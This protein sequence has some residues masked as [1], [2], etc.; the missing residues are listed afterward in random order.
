MRK[1]RF[2][3]FVLALLCLVF[4]NCAPYRAAVEDATP[5]AS[6]ADLNPNP[7]PSP[8]PGPPMTPAPAPAPAPLPV[9]LPAPV[10]LRFKKISAAGDKT[11]GVTM[12]DTVQCWGSTGTVVR[13]L[14][15]FTSV[16]EIV[17]G[18][19]FE[20]ILTLGGGVKCMGASNF[21]GQL[22]NGTT[23][24]SPTIPVDVV[25]LSAG[26]TSLAVGSSH[27]CAVTAAGAVVCWGYNANGQLGNNS[28]VASSVP[29]NAVGVN[30]A[31]AVATGS[32]HSCALLNT[33]A[34]RCWGFYYTSGQANDVITPFTI[35][36]L[37]GAK[38]ITAAANTTCVIDAGDG[39]RCW[40]YNTSGILADSS[41]V[42]LQI[43][44]LTGVT[45]FRMSSSGGC[46]LTN[47][48]AVKCLGTP[49][50]G[51]QILPNLSLAIPTDVLP[52]NSAKGLTVS[53]Q[54][55]CL[56]TLTDTVKCMGLNANGQLGN[57]GVANSNT[58]PMSSSLANFR[59][60]KNGFAHSC[61]LTST[62][63]LRC[64]GS[65]SSR[66]LGDNTAIEAAS[67]VD[68]LNSTG[69]VDFAVAR[70]HNCAIIGPTRI[71]RCW[72]NNYVSDVDRG[73]LGNESTTSNGTPVDVAGLSGVKSLSLGDTHSCAVLANDSVVCWGSNRY[74]QL[75]NN[76]DITQPPF[77]NYPP[78]GSPSFTPMPTVNVADVQELASGSAHSCALL[79]S[80]TVKCWGLNTSGQLGVNSVVSSS[81]PADVP[82]LTGIKKI[83]ASGAYTCAITATNTVKCW[84][85]NTT[86]Q[87]GNALAVNSPVPVD[88][89]GLVNVASITASLTHACATLN[90][91]ELRCWG[92][93]RNGQ[94][95]D[96]TKV[97]F[98]PVPV[99]FRSRYAGYE[100]VAGNGYTLQVQAAGRVHITGRGQYRNPMLNGEISD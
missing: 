76:L 37:T 51:S 74:G 42:P 31:I 15:G 88:V 5:Q 67:P 99:I 48:G 23:T 77:P 29:V 12:T 26:V 57:N 30:G 62:G 4:Q 93:N 7:N 20:C 46:A 95:G 18:S 19:S 35:P 83:V 100:A 68:V 22:G 24:A 90:S 9:P 94:L 40:G 97:L 60:V 33:G 80:G 82:G 70:Y 27:A 79:K 75:G 6:V 98:S 36:N 56:H 92:G 63:A 53:T 72:G 13:D 38:A 49:T 78:S 59:V 50:L 44:N 71:V 41:L 1:N 32:S 89:Q 45:A 28:K 16:R 10:P 52:A 8:T 85:L 39:V 34:V 81:L 43:P 87:L 55:M 47:N 25:G 66:V 84:G 61:G 2:A 91:G 17:H 58:A 3:F 14:E 65:N 96:L 64:W 86:G 73:L 69:T 11:C 54:H 21:S